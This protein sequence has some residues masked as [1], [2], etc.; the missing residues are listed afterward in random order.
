MTVAWDTE[1]AKLFNAPAYIARFGSLGSKQFSTHPVKS[2]T[3]TTVVC[4]GLPTGVSQTLAPLQ[5]RATVGEV[6]L[7]LADVDGEVTA[8]VA[9]EAS[10]APLAT[11]INERITLL[12]GYRELPESD[13][14]AAFTG[15]VRDVELSGDPLIYRFTVVELK[16]RWEEDLCA[17]IGVGRWPTS[18]SR[19]VAL[20]RDAP[21]G[22]TQLETRQELDLGGGFPPTPATP[23]LLYR[24]D[25]SASEI[26]RVTQ[27]VVQP[28][29]LD[30]AAPTTVAFTATDADFLSAAP[31]V[32]G[33]II[34]VFYAFLTNNFSTDPRD[35]GYPLVEVA[36]SPT[37]LG[38]VDADLDLASFLDTRDR[39]LGD[40]EVDIFITSPIKARR[41]F[42]EELFILGAYPTVA[43]DG[44]LGI[45]CFVPPG[46]EETSPAKVYKEH[47]VSLPRLIR[48]IATHLNR[49]EVLGDTN[50]NAAASDIE[51]AI[52][53][54]TADQTTSQETG[55]LVIKSRGLRT[56][57]EG[58]AVATEMAQRII[59]RWLVP[60]VELEVEVAFTK[61]TL[62]VGQIVKVT[63]PALPDVRAGTMGLTDGLFEITRVSVDYARGVVRLT[64][65]DSGYGRWAWLGPVSMA[66]Y[67]AA[68]ATEKLYAYFGDANNKVNSG[69]EDGYIK[70]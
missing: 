45:R 15:E 25:G 65:L 30:L 67:G 64:L 6:T 9:T 61:R 51:L 18:S 23:V 12:A 2:P 49:V 10:G 58:V 36:G 26:V 66:D 32:R 27:Q 3:R 62:A 40:I 59:A 20:N 53:E 21:I 57:R 17:G 68:S 70:F 35:T 5:N 34:N 31:R 16:R 44:T 24:A 48:R 29:L 43:G 42:E 54:D 63:H 13:Y 56:S 47:M 22:T 69:T 4:M 55:L 1:T 50:P 41:F 11:L 39:Y 8:L 19:V 7:S 52:V 28:K 60:P 33:N 37:G 46:P 38:L 14:Q